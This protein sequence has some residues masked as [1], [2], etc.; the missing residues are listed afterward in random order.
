[1]AAAVT[2]FDGA[3]LREGTASR[4]ADRIV[5]RPGQAPA[6]A[7][8]LDGVITGL[9]TDHHVHLQ[10]VDPSALTSSRLGRVIDLGADVDVMRRYKA[11]FENDG[12]D[13]EYAGPFLTAVGGYPSDRDWAPDRAVHQVQDAAD[14]AAMIGALAAAGVG[15][16][17]VVGNSDAGPVLDDELFRAV[18]R[19][20]AEHRLPVVAHAEGAGQAQRVAQLGAARL[21]HSPFSERL[22]DEEIEL[23][24][25]SVSWISTM[26]IHEGEPYAHVVDN[27]R[28][29]VT[30]GGEL[31]YGS[32]MGN[33]DT[34]VDLR[35]S[36]IAALRDAGL[37]GIDLLRVLA[38]AGIGSGDLLLL[39]DGDPV[40]ARR[41][42]PADLEA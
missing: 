11:R 28:R 30:A 21:A 35:D 38:P 42:T 26:A 1:M 10:L 4:D 41:L 6:G 17:K 3:M 31:V 16:I 22:S 40:H 27:V 13:L 39:P 7:P 2:Y 8:L 32:D 5:V 18:V 14:A 24:A 15:C 9:F 29:F 25:A 37:K 12:I 33:G 34:P 20:A 36:E 19:E 23:Q